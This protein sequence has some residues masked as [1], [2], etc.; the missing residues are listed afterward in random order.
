MEEDGINNSTKISGSVYTVLVS[1][2]HRKWRNSLT[3]PVDLPETHN[4]DGVAVESL[5]LVIEGGTAAMASKCMCVA[6]A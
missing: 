5:E 2:I 6:V 3:G 1:K 4:R